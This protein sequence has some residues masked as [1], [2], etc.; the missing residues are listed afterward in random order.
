[1][2]DRLLH[3]AR[4][5]ARTLVPGDLEETLSRITTAAVE[6][7]P[8]FAMPGMTLRHSDNRLQTVARTHDVLYE[9]DA[10]QYEFQQRPCYEAVTEES[11]AS[12]PTFAADPS[13]AFGAP[14]S[15]IFPSNDHAPAFTNRGTARCSGTAQ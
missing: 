15:R 5:L 13:K 14:S 6:V 1:M 3:H 8:G 11:Y 4:K 2:D 7:L 12:P 9:V 10:K